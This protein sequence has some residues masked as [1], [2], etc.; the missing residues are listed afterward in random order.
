MLTRGCGLRQPGAV[1]AV[2]ALSAHG[3]PLEY[4]IVDPPQPVDCAGLG[5]TDRGVRI[6]NTGATTV[7]ADVVGT[8]YYPYATDFLEEVR[9]FGASRRLSPKLDFSQ[10]GPFSRLWLI[11]RRAYLNNFQVLVPRVQVICPKYVHPPEPEVC[12]INLLYH[13]FDPQDVALKSDA[14]PSRRMPAFEYP[15]WTRP[16]GYTPDYV[17]ALFLNLPISRLEVV[18]AADG[19]HRSA[20]AR[21]RTSSLEVVEVDA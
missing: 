12:C 7:V 2:T 20:L 3:V 16:A 14:R 4:F 9:R 17:P 13:V 6:L 8:N 10:L 15:V 5:L 1:Y 18:R 11:H 19:S 21:A